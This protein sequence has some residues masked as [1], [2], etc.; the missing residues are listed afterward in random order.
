MIFC[1]GKFEQEEVSVSVI[2]E[3]G[4]SGHPSYKYAGSTFESRRKPKASIAEVNAE[5]SRI[6]LV[7]SAIFSIPLVKVSELTSKQTPRPTLV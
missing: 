6:R 3:S 1:L 2:L 5:I 7:T 4:M